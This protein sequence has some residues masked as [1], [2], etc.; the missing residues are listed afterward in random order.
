[1][2]IIG[3]TQQPRGFDIGRPA[4]LIAA[5]PAVLGFVPE[6]SLTIVTL[7]GGEMGC[8]MRVDLTPGLVGNTAALA[9]VVAG[10]GHAA[11]RP[12]I[13]SASY[14]SSAWASYRTCRPR[15]MKHCGPVPA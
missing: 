8:V 1:M 13:S 5:L 6:H 7:D 14:L 15:L 11:H 9:E 10:S 12:P 3:M 2:T 4:S